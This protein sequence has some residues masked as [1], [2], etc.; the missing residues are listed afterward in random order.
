M[1]NLKCFPVHVTIPRLKSDSE[2]MEVAKKVI[3]QILRVKRGTFVC[4]VRIES[5]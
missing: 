4:L 5:I 2:F 1:K 3:V